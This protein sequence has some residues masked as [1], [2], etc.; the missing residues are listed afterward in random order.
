MLGVPGALKWRRQG[1]DLVIETPRLP[2]DQLP[3]RYAYAFK[4][5]GVE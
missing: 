3:C 2:V 1:S 4:I 5:S